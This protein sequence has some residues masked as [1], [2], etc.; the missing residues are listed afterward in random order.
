MTDKEKIESYSIENLKRE[1]TFSRD[2][3]ITSCEHFTE[4]IEHLMQSHRHN[5][6][7]LILT[8]DGDGCHT[9]DFQDY[10]LKK[11]RVFLINYGQVH[12][13]KQILNLKG[14]VVL[15]TREFYNLIYTGNEIMKSEDALEG[16]PAFI[17]LN[18]Q[19]SEEWVHLLEQIEQE[20]QDAKTHYKEIIC[21]LIKALIIRYNGNWNN[22][23]QSQ[24]KSIIKN[25]LIVK[26]RKLINQHFQEW[27]LPRYYAA[28][29]FV[30]PNYLNSVCNEITGRSAN[31]LIKDRVV[32]EASR[33]LTHSHLTINQIAFN[34]GFED[35]SYFSKYFKS[36]TK[37]TPL[38]FRMTFSG[39]IGIL[40]IT[41][42]KN[43]SPYLNEG[44]VFA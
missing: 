35:N 15:F 31:G 32:L 1:V 19:E 7:A 29:L 13:W 8:T 23:N 41:L 33:L 16:G 30:T 40:L 22:E 28:E 39:N 6:Y 3:E 4:N 11:G 18:D 42:Y 5:F 43:I 44:G 34:L 12:A 27:K 26:F 38:K 36:K 10:I 17:D 20:F 25:E 21:L 9:I 2:F 14:F 24:T 37:M